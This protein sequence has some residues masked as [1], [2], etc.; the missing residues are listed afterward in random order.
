MIKGDVLLTGGSG[1]IG[2]QIVRSLS[3]EN[4]TVLNLD[5][6][7]ERE[8]YKNEI[9]LKIDLSNF[10]SNQ[11]EYKKIINN[12]N[13]WNV[14]H[15][16][17]YGGKFVT[18]DELGMDDWNKIFQINLNSIYQI[19]INFLPL[20]KKNKYGRFVA[21]ASS[22][23]IVGAKY[24]VAYSS[25]KHALLGFTKSVGAEWG[26]YGI[27]SNSI[28]PGYVETDM[29]VQELEVGDHRKKILEMTPSKKIAKPE[30]IARVVQFILDGDSGYINGSNWTV[31][32]GITAI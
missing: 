6:K 23:S 21:I 20:W 12:L 25:S 9:F 5:Q 2:S 4:I 15:C 31:D 24:S 27:T 17:G 8:L 18:I 19:L 13:I 7:L 16:A 3:G 28:S 1:G 30:E 26:E 32:G 22:L 14:V 11:T 29:G 10:S